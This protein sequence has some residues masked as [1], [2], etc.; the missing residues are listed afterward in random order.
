V[1]AWADPSDKTQ[2]FGALLHAV[3]AVP[4]VRRLRYM[5]SHPRDVGEAMVRAHAEIPALMPYLHLPVQ[6]GSDRI[7]EAMNRK[8]DRRFYLDLIARFRESR[9]DLAVTSDFIVGF[10]GETDADFAQTLGIV[11]EVGYAQAFSFKYSPRLGTPAAEREDQVAESVKAERL[12]RLQALVA[13]RSLAFNRAMVGRRTEILIERRGRKPGQWIGKSPWLQSVVVEA[14]D[15]KSGA[16]V[17][18]VL[19]DVDLVAAGPNSL[20]GRNLQMRDSE[21]W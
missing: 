19:V 9:A 20:E 21:T 18:G 8:H 16:L 14:D 5:T 15:L 6:S 1:N 2:D 11:E 12:Q 7:L 4:G 17:P 3:A 13:D 10:P